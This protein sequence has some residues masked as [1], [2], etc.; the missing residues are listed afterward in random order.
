MIT[1]IVRIYLQQAI[2]KS[3]ALQQFGGS[4]EK[5]RDIRGLV[6]KHYILSDDGS[7]TGAVY[8]WESRQ[9][10]EAF[11]NEDWRKFIREKYGKEPSVEYYETPVIVDMEAGTTWRD[12]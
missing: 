2:N 4:A 7:T 3:Q 9:D 1:A 10:A 8:L 6:R 12:D 11:L 5:Y